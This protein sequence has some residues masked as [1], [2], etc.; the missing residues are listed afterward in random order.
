[1]RYRSGWK[2]GRVKLSDYPTPLTDAHYANQLA[3]G[4]NEKNH[5][6]ARDIERKLAMC[7]DRIKRVMEG[8]SLGYTAQIQI[9][10]TLEQTK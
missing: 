10:K 7:R 2:G 1:M 4:Q 5:E 3:T 6:H 8:G 9:A